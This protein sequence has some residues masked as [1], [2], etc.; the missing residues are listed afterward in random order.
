METSFQVSVN[1]S[2]SDDIVVRLEIKIKTN[3]KEWLSTFF[4]FFF[5][6]VIYLFFFSSISS[7]LLKNS[8]QLRLDKAE[9]PGDNSWCPAIRSDRLTIVLLENRVN[10]STDT[11]SLCLLLRNL[12][13]WTVKLP[14]HGGSPVRGI[15]P[16][17]ETYVLV[18]L[19]QADW[20]ELDLQHYTCRLTYS[21]IFAGTIRLSYF[22]SLGTKWNC[23]LKN[24]LY[25]TANLSISF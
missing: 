14:L 21:N 9:L 5:V 8:Y 25:L 13:S 7:V 10:R 11:L 17:N 20:L 2:F 3:S 12:P 22:Y 24:K 1:L 19:Y 6:E 18:F 4:C 23:K 16:I 15:D